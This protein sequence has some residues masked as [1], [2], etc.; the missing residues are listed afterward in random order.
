MAVPFI[1]EGGN[2][3]GKKK[4]SEWEEF[5]N[6]HN[7]SLSVREKYAKLRVDH[8][9]NMNYIECQGEMATKELTIKVIQEL[10]K[11][12]SLPDDIYN[13]V[14]GKRDRIIR[15]RHID[16]YRK[17]HD[18]AWKEVSDK[19]EGYVYF[20]KEYHGNAVKIGFA[21]NPQKRINQMIFVPSIPVEILHTIRS[22]NA[23][24]LEQLFHNHFYK[25]RI[26][27]GFTTEFFLLTDEDMQD[28]YNRNLPEEIL[29]LIVEEKD[30]LPLHLRRLERQKQLRQEK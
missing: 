22:Q 20:L 26:K 8:D 12:V 6:K 29:N 28:I 16:S 19:K 13:D 27:D 24:R 9:T 5:I 21:K 30:I 14:K 15:E 10:L 7:K 11:L 1:L 25:K 3:M 2:R 23:Q 18:I 4:R 17:T